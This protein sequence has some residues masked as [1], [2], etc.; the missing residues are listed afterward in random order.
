M[1]PPE[2]AFAD[3][4]KASWEFGAWVGTLSPD[5]RIHLWAKEH[6]RTVAALRASPVV[7]ARLRQR[8]AE[9]LRGG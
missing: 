4:I 2:R 8:L 1:T 5:E 7:Q 9:R 6:R 3:A